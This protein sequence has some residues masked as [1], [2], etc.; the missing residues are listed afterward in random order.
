MHV[1]NIISE[2]K[3]KTELKSVDFMH[4]KH[5][6]GEPHCAEILKNIDRDNLLERG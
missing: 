1:V 3:S 5:S 4:Y 2:K 6:I